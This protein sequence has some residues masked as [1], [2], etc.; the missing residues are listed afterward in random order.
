M[1]H[2]ILVASHN[3]FEILMSTM[4][5]LD[6]ENID[7]YIHIDKKSKN[8][9]FE[10]LNGVCKK[11]SVYFIPRFSVN[12][13]GFSLVECP[14]ELLRAA[15]KNDYDY[16]H[17][18]SGVDHPIKTK[19]YFLNF[20][21]TRDRNIEYIHFEQEVAKRKYVERLMYHS[22]FQDTGNKYLQFLDKLI[23]HFEKFI[24]YSRID[25]KKYIFQYGSNWFSITHNFAK[26]VLSKEQWVRSVF[27]NAFAGDELLV[28]TLI[29]NSDFRKNLP[30]NA[31]NN[32]YRTC[33]RCVDWKRGHPY[34]FRKEDFNYL[35]ESEC[36]FARKFDLNVD[37]AIIE[38]L[39]NYC[40]QD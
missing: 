7:F 40:K 1:K 13:G 15:T 32:D 29:V 4:S 2:A 19:Q 28:Q 3:Q 18:I 38:L 30:P 36:L 27:K 11:S 22:F 6:D 12:W 37:A 8:V 21:E 5:I 35:V 17:Y 26:Y 23:R 31:F 20:F 33:L 24:H 14:I 10:E 25:E 9:P 16:Y 34:I 39:A